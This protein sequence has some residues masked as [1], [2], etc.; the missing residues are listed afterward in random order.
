VASLNRRGRPSFEE[1]IGS[2]DAVRASS[3][4][5]K[6][7]SL[8]KNQL[9]Q[10]EWMLFDDAVRD[11]RYAWRT[12]VRMPML[13][14]VVVVS[15]GIGIGVNTA[16]FSWIQAVVL[17]PIPGVES[18]SSFYLV[19]TRADTGSYPGASWLEYRDFAES[20]RSFRELVA[21]RMVPLNVGDPDRSEQ[22]YGLLVSDNYFSALGL[23]PA[24]GHFPQANEAVISYGFWKARFDRSPEAVGQTLRINDQVVEIAGV[25]PDGF[26]GTV[27]GVDFDFWVPV[28]LAPSLF[29]GSRELEDRS[30]RGYYI[31]GKLRSGATAQQAQTEVSAAMRQFAQLYPAASGNFKAEVL[32]YWRAPR[33]PQRF[34]VTGLVILQSIMLLLLVAVC[35]NTANLLLARATARGREVG[36]RLALGATRWRIVRLLMTESLLLALFGAALGAVIAVW[37]TEALRAARLSM[38]IP[39]RFQT[40]INTAGFTVAA[41]L[42]VPCAAIFGIAPA[43]QLVRGDLQTKLRSN[44]GSVPATRLRQWLMAAEAAIALM[45]LLAAA[46]F[47]ESF[48]DTRTL[49]PGFQIEGILLSAYDLR[50]SAGHRQPDGR[51]DPAFSRL[52]ADQL[53]ERL[54]G[55]PGV[56]SAAIATSV[57]LDIHGMPMFSFNLPGKENNDGTPQRSLVNVV[58]PDYFATMKIQ[59]LE[60]PGFVSLNN[61]TVD[62]QIVVN[63]EYVRRFVA[64]GEPIGRQ[65]NINGT[66]YAVAG[67]VRNSFYDAFGEAPIPIV[68]FSY[69]DRPRASGEIHVRTRAGAETLIAGEVRR[70]VREV[71]SGVPVFNVRTLGEHVETNLFLRRIPAR[72]FIVL[73]PLLL[74]FAAIG[75]YSVVAY[76]VSHRITEIGVRMALGASVRDVVRDIV[77]ETIKVIAF[78]ALVG[79]LITVVVYIHLVRGGKINLVV[80]GGVP[81]ILLLVAAAASWLPARRAAGLDPVLA[82]RQE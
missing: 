30:Q 58:T 23:R 2:R 55:V 14:V 19:E 45:V 15:L 41:M 21:F 44:F 79:V 11:F 57:P 20:L 3:I 69:R 10:W 80:F 12:I 66:R 17:Q 53:L 72:L 56:E 82:L 36:T 81:G 60:G 24:V 71:E 61:T 77:A 51:T 5:D 43:L 9:H 33:G 25:V 22:R 37:G 7:E 47:F 64:A 67:V 32:P 59:L 26:Q 13:A 35:G 1:G 48:R 65:F 18:P 50:D 76:N 46:L 52:F 38:A 73:G 54:R 68:Y 49:D 74:F 16:V 42:G 29:A 63:Q 39:I 8:M 62:P 31:M 40:S 70:V 4:G 6:F 28:R 27:L 34:L 78:G 75:I